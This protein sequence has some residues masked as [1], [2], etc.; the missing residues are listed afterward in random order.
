MKGH[1]YAL[2][3]IRQIDP[4]MLPALH[5]PAVTVIQNIVTN[6]MERLD[7]MVKDLVDLLELRNVK[8]V[9]DVREGLDGLREIK[10]MALD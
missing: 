2:D 4:D 10:R 1:N 5:E 7:M 3:A 6:D 8:R 9:R